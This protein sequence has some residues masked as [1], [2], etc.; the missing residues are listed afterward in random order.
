[1][2]PDRHLPDAQTGPVQ[3]QEHVGIGIVTGKDFRRE[4]AND[5]TIEGLISRGGIGNVYAN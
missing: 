5:P 1:M 3:S 2:H 4:K